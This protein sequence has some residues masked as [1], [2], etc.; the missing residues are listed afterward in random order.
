MTWNY[1]VLKHGDQEFAIHEVYYH[2]DGNPRMCSERAISPYG[3]TLTELNN[4]L[5]HMTDAL[6]QP[7]L[8]YEDLKETL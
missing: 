5:A 7:V 6:D 8:N 2:P 4:D 3:E 1:R